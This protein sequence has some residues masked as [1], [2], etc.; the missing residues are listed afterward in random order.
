MAFPT[1]KPDNVRME[2]TEFH[3]VERKGAQALPTD[4]GAIELV[5]HVRDWTPCWRR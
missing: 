5:L 4:I 3:N 2:F 1:F